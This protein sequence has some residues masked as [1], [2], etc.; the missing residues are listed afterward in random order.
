MK[1]PTVIGK[2]MM[3]IRMNKYVKTKKQIKRKNRLHI[4]KL[5]QN[6]KNIWNIIRDI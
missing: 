1:I 3:K 2:K 5:I 4:R 6:N